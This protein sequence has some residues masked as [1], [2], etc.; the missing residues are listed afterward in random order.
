MRQINKKKDKDK[1]AVVLMLCFCVIALTSIFT[2]KAN[3][4][5]VKENAQ[6]IPVVEETQS[7]QKKEPVKQ[8]SPT[9]SKT[10]QSDES[11]V[12]TDI[13]TIDSNNGQTTTSEF[14]HPINS[15]NATVTNPYSMDSLIYSVTLDQF[16]THCGT[17]ISA[18]ED[19]QVVAVQEGTVTSIYQDDRYGISIE[20]THPG[21]LITVYSNLSTSEMVEIGDVVKQGQ[22]IGGVGST[23]LF[24]SSEPA[25][26]HFEVI[27]DGS[28]V[29]PAD[30]ISF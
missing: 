12:S 22:I 5:K 8:S 19:S 21:K 13:P 17:D 26:L 18:P 16:M 1:V 27:K 23:G 11:D 6:N 29:N 9:P 28:Y 3:I 20:V 2:V 10:E 30:Y 25:H 15:P 4:D 14:I 24:E 7:E